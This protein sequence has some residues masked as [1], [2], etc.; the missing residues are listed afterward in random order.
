MILFLAGDVMTGRGIDQVLPQPSAPELHESYVRSAVG[1]VRLAEEA[2]GPIPGPVDG[3]YLWGD[4]RPELDRMAPDARI[5]NLETAITTSDAWWKT[6][7]IHYRMHPANVEVLTTL[8][9]D[10]C[11]LANNHVLDWGRGGLLQT[12]QTLDRA[13]LATVG[14]GRDP[15]EATRPA[16]LDTARGRLQLHAWAAGSAGVPARW[17]PGPDTPGVN[18]L[19]SLDAAATARVIDAA[20]SYRRDGDR[21]VVSIHWGGNWGYA[22]PADQR[23]FAR[24]LIDAEAADVVFGHSSH[25]PKGLEIYRDRLIVYGAGDFLNDYEGIGGRVE[26]RGELVLAYFPELEPDGRLR[27]LLLS[28]FRIRRFRLERA[29]PEE[30]GW[31]AAMI[32][33]ESV[34]LGTVEALDDGRL[35]VP[36]TDA[37]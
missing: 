16:V 18:R 26:Y 33:R 9:V 11:I 14:A 31:I 21:V 24:A 17:E 30:L 10:V 37:G 36:G 1:Y 2:S 3:A 7:G 34:G 15:A 5:V 19:G 27:Q 8:G 32:A 20:H 23:A 12:L 25:H 4:A 29:T 28:P 22:V 13:G 35:R 6:K